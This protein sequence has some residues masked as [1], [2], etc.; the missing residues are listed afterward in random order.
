[1]SMFLINGVFL[2]IKWHILI[3]KLYLLKFALYQSSGIWAQKSH[4]KLYSGRIGHTDWLIFIYRALVMTCH[5]RSH[6]IFHCK[7]P[8]KFLFP[9]LQ[10]TRQ[11]TCITD[12]YTF[13]CTFLRHMTLNLQ[14]GAGWA[15]GG[16]VKGAIPGQS[17]L[18]SQDTASCTAFVVWLLA[19]HLLLLWHDKSD[20]HK[21]QTM[22]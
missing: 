22:S 3:K 1:M 16:S 15:Q 10:F 4:V 18:C 19:P 7:P 14:E 2:N 9:F 5:L 13:L 21:T 8:L 20:R 11:F 12:V 6:N 17:D